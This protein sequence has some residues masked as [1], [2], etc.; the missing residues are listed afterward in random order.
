MTT[1]NAAF[2][3]WLS[4]LDKAFIRAHGLSYQDFPDWNWR[5]AFDDGLTPLQAVEAYDE[6]MEYE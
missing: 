1:D 6:E 3:A 4:Q 2:T 5:D